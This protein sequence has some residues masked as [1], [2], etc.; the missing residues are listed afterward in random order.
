MVKIK[1]FAVLRGLAGKDEISLTL[2]EGSTL[3]R[4]LEK[5][6]TDFPALKEVIEKGG[7]LISVNQEV[8][9][10]QCLIQDGDE[11]ALL[12]PFAGG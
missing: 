7:I 1:F 11:I 3:E 8:A 10:K 5:L 12:P 9:E 6:K 2:E 4:L